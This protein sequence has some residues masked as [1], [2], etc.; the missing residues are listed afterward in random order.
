VEIRVSN[1]CLLAQFGWQAINPAE[2]AYVVGDQP[3]SQ[4]RTIY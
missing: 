4:A 2:F 1:Y 3:N